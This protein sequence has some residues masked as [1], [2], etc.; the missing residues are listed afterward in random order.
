MGWQCRH[1]PEGRPG[2][3]VSTGA[4]GSVM[5]PAQLA[6]CNGKNQKIKSEDGKRR[7]ALQPAS[8]LPTLRPPWPQTLNPLVSP[9]LAI[10]PSNAVYPPSAPTQLRPT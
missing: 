8:P 1:P 7:Q 5:A 3:H 6:T 4:A 2:S 9:R 10:R